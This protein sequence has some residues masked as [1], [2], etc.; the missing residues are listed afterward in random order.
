MRIPY[1]KRA[2][3]MP[4]ECRHYL[5]RTKFIMLRMN[6][7]A[8]QT[9]RLLCTGIVASLACGIVQG[10]E[11][12][13]PSNGATIS[14]PENIIWEKVKKAKDQSKIDI[15]FVEKIGKLSLSDQLAIWLELIEAKS[16]YII[17]TA[18]DHLADIVANAE[19]DHSDLS[20]KALDSIR[21]L[22]I[23][24]ELSIRTAALFVLSQYVDD[25]EATRNLSIMLANPDTVQLAVMGLVALV[26][27]HPAASERLRYVMSDPET[28]PQSVAFI[29]ENATKNA[30][31]A[32]L[33]VLF[34]TLDDSRTTI[35]NERIK[36]RLCD[37]ALLAIESIYGLNPSATFLDSNLASKNEA[38]NE[39]KNWAKTVDDLEKADPAAE[40]SDKKMSTALTV[41]LDKTSPLER[42]QNARLFFE[43]K[44]RR[45]LCLGL[46]PGIDIVSAPSVK[47]LMRIISALEP[48]TEGELT[49]EWHNL[50]T[51]IRQRLLV[52]QPELDKEP[53]DRQAA[54]FMVAGYDY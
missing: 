45:Q 14:G 2:Y 42:R 47:E 15:E 13:Y 6:R 38:I 51:K 8:R 40:M 5:H 10:E 27:S 37:H 36:Y 33:P 19:I 4:R 1:R 7:F 20:E 17:L 43:D 49:Q 22:T 9:I 54:S 35:S 34:A 30:Q 50:D 41:F 3:M 32:F 46:L 12:T 28:P 29:M 52:Q 48:G 18:V 16:N 23:H 26:P 44:F 24:N 11:P 31:R 25:Q 39:W 21:A 53:L